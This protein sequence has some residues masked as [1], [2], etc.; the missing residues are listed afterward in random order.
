MN[1][2]FKIDSGIEKGDKWSTR[3]SYGIHPS[4]FGL[5]T[6]QTKG[7][8]EDDDM[9]AQ[10]CLQET[11][12]EDDARC[13]DVVALLSSDT[14]AVKLVNPQNGQERNKLGTIEGLKDEVSMTER[15]AK[16]CEEAK[17]NT[18]GGMERSTRKNLIIDGLKEDERQMWVEMDIRSDNIRNR[19][20]FKMGEMGEPSWEN[21]ST[22][23]TDKCTPTVNALLKNDETS[24]GSVGFKKEL[25]LRNGRNGSK[26]DGLNHELS[27]PI[28]L[29]RLT[30]EKIKNGTHVRL[31]EADSDSF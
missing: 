27:S 6:E 17:E 3:D 9:A 26:D 10:L 2:D 20:N 25:D 11:N 28:S 16:K 15:A 13:L 21:S 18:M 5:E 7:S 29:V 1:L 12:V 19:H 24:N 23:V 4:L 30:K 8:E 22:C 31:G 14:S